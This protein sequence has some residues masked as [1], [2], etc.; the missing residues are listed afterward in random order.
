MS[1]V[2]AA[3][4]ARRLRAAAA[5]ATAAQPPPLW[6]ASEAQPGGFKGVVVRDGAFLALLDIGEHSTAQ[7]L[8][9][10]CCAVSGMGGMGL[11]RLGASC[12][13]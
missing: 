12:I 6:E 5:A 2:K 4:T 7:H 10:C 8:L 11:P 1:E 3:C 13:Q 9:V